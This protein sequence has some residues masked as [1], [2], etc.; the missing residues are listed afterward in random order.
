[1]YRPRPRLQNQSFVDKLRAMQIGTQTA[2]AIA[3]HFA[4]QPIGVQK[5]HGKTIGTTASAQQQQTVG[6]NSKV[7]VTHST[8]QCRLVAIPL[9]CTVVYDDEIVAAGLH[10]GERQTHC[11]DASGVGK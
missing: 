6:P 10:L 8:G 4:H 2:C 5:A 11:G 9:A 1:V 3:A 7:T